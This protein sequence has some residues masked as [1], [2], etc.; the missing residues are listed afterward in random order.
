MGK[1]LRRGVGGT[2]GRKVAS[3]EAVRTDIHPEEEAEFKLFRFKVD[4]N[5][6]FFVVGPFEGDENEVNLPFGKYEVL[7]TAHGKNLGRVEQRFL[8]HV[9]KSG[10]VEFRTV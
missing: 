1:T 3:N 5:H 8:V 6:D 10:V 4:G 9:E 7:L 2:V